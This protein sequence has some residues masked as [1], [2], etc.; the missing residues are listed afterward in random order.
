M[1]IYLTIDTPIPP[2]AP[3]AHKYTN[4]DVSVFP[5][6]Y[7]T[8]PLPA[9]LR[10]GAGDSSL[11]KC[12]TV[13]STPTTP[14]PTLPVSLPDYAMYLHAVL[15]ASRRANNDSTSGFRKLAKMVDSLYPQSPNASG[16][17]VEFNGPDRRGVSGLFKRVLGRDKNHSQNQRGG[18]ADVFE[19]ITP[20]RVDEYH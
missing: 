4:G 17:G 7:T 3:N 8:S 16:L 5:F 18:N 15:E 19:F 2:Q 13:P 6:S 1:I 11:S 10:A 14:F 9:L 12:F 20:F